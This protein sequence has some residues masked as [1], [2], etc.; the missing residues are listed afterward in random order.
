MKFGSLIAIAVASGALGCATFE[1]DQAVG[2]EFWRADSWRGAEVIAVG[3]ASAPAATAP[4]RSVSP[5]PDKGDAPSSPRFFAIG[6]AHAKLGNVDISDCWSGTM[7]GYG[8]LKVTFDGD[9]DAR[10]VEVLNPVRG[11]PVPDRTCVAERIRAV[12]MPAFDGSPVA[13]KT[14]FWVP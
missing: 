8:H 1:Q 2:E 10:L 6:A 5:S 9:G 12:A 14:T 4:S 13:V 7:R 11:A 3:E